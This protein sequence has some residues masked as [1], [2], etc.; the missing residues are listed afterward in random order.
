MSNSTIQ[1]VPQTQY[2]DAQQDQWELERKRLEQERIQKENDRIA[3][4]QKAKEDEERKRL[5]KTSHANDF[6]EDEFDQDDLAEQ[7]AKPLV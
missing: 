6:D 3:L 2:K 4:I 1:V 5:Q 7:K